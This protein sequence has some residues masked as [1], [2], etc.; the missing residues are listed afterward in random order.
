MQTVR[1]RADIVIQ[2][3]NGAMLALVEVKNRQGLSPEIAAEFR[4]NLIAHGA[5]NREARFF[6]L[7][8]QEVG[9]LWDQRS[10]PNT[11]APRPTVTFPMASVVDHYLPSLMG[12]ARL[13]GSQLELAV[14]Q[15]LWDLANDAEERPREPEAALA[16]TDFLPRIKGGRVG[17]EFD[18]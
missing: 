3:A 5:V 12:S 13:S 6:L 16:N 11:E 18:R 7:V 8:S 15:W 1:I 2:D 9:Y 4:R 10:L 14:A 17:T